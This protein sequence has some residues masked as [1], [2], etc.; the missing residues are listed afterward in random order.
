VGGIAGMN[1]AKKGNGN[2]NKLSDCY[3]V[4]EIIG[5]IYAGGITGANYSTMNNCYNIGKVTDGDT[6]DYR[7]TGFLNKAVTN[8]YFLY[9][10]DGDATDN[11]YT[12]STYGGTY[13]TAE[14]FVS[15]EVAYLLNSGKTDGTQ[16][17]YQNIGTDNYPT[18]DSTRGTV[19][20]GY[21][22]CLLTYANSA[23]SAAQGDHT[24]VAATCT[25]PKTCSIC[26]ATEGEKDSSAHTGAKTWTTTEYKHK[27]AWS[28][29]G[30]EI[31]A[32]ADHT[33]VNGVCS[34]CEYECEYTGGTTDT[35]ADNPADD[36]T[37]KKTDDETTGEPEEKKGLS[38]GAIAGSVIG[39]V[40]V[41]GIGGFA[42]FWFVIKKKSF[43]DL[44]A[45]FKKK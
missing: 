33:F 2:N 25:T 9:N 20:N 16:A 21:N 24:W 39:S 29:C 43:A 36:N 13:K 30:A 8:C 41:A 1:S 17:Y 15:G 32:E 7:I 42:I 31:V 18:L 10:A 14:Q 5:T 3:N 34:V 38:G 19:Y 37:D 23:L 40:A 4:G 22:Q 27:Q 6:T 12:A 35:P 26:G 28:C 45:V 11:E 44:I